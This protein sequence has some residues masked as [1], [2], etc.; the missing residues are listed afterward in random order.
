[1]RIL[2]DGT[3]IKSNPSGVGLHL[4]NL[5]HWLYILQDR[6]SLNFS[7][8][9]GISY[10]PGL[11]NWLKGKQIFPDLINSYPNL[12]SLPIPVRLVNPFLLYA[13]TLFCNCFEPTLGYPDIIHGTNYL[14]YPF[15]RSLKILNIYDLTFIKYPEYVDA[16]VGKYFAVVKQCLTWTDLIISSSESIKQD[17]IEYLSFPAERIHVTPLASRYNHKFI[18]NFKPEILTS[19]FANYDFTKPYILFVSTIEPRKNIKALITAF[20]SLKQKYKIEHNLV[21]IG[22]KGWNYTPIFEAIANSAY[23]HNIYH[24]DYLS[25]ELVA[26]FYAKADVFVYPSHYEGFGLPILEAMTLGAPV[27]TSNVSSMPEVGG[28]AAVLIDPNNSEELAESILKVISDRNFRNELITKGQERAKAF[29]WE[30]TALATL[31]GYQ[32]VLR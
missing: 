2:I 32:K 6:N 20:N 27:I 29:S 18:E 14:V 3:P 7:Y 9:M 19:S 26:A 25:D 12:Y 4:L 22:Q 17:I 11:K 13:P 10:Q 15:K 23:T 1:M 21:L 5:I 30:K 16:V 28:N 8:E 31:E 24:L